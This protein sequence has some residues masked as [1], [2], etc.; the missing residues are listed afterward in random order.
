MFEISVR[1]GFSGAHRLKGYKGKC[2]SLHGHN[3]DVEVFVTS[4]KLDSGGL[5]I[6]FKDLKKKLGAVLEIL[7]HRDLNG[8]AFFRKEN[9]SAE[10]IAKYIYKNLKQSLNGGGPKVS[11]KKVSVWETKDSCASYFE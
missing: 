6:D 8:I 3:W 7:D 5:T 9:P 1:S 10:N 2:E 4:K 11:I